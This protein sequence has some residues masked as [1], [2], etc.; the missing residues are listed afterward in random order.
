[1]I[2]ARLRQLLGLRPGDR[3]ALSLEPEGLLLKPQT[4]RQTSSARGLIGCSGYRGPTMPLE[5]MDPA[6]DA[7]AAGMERGDDR[8]GLPVVLDT[9]VLVRLLTNDDPEQASRAAERIDSSSSCFV[10]IT[11]VLELEW[12]LRAAYRLPRKALIQALDFGDAL[13]LSRS[14]GCGALMSFD[15]ALGRATEELRL[16]PGV[17]EP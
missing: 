3:L 5:R 4:N 14:T 17:L 16:S 6:L 12:L 10:P 13:H 8:M 7:V 9:N 2:P 15:R 11:V 1:V